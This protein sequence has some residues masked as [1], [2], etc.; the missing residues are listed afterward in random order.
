MIIEE[1]NPDYW[2]R[3]Y[4]D[5]SNVW[6]AGD[7]ST[8]LKHYFDQLTSKE[9]KILIPGAGNGYEAEYLFN[10]G[11]KNTCLLDYA[12][13]P[14]NEFKKRVPGFPDSQLIHQDFFKHEGKYD[15]IIEQTFFCALH[16]SLRNKYALHMH[17]LLNEKGKLVGLLF[18]NPMANRV[19]PPFGGT[20]EE[21][22][23]Y[24]SPLFNIKTFDQCYNS[25]PPRKGNEFFIILGKK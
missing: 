22:L 15:L 8:P 12:I 7:V 13:Y 9:T 20:E 5:G 23:K 16:P 6:D 1:L 25:I 19:P 18:N 4:T 24:F 10:A 11:F 21:Y 14:L 3:R 2:Q 17:R